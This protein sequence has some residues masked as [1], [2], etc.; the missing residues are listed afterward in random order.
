MLQG[1]FFF[2]NALNTVNVIACFTIPIRKFNFVCA[3]ITHTR[4]NKHTHA[5]AVT[6]YSL[7][8][9][10]IRYAPFVCVGV[11]VLC[12]HSFIE[13]LF[14]KI[15]IGKKER[16]ESQIESKQKSQQQNVHRN[17]TFIVY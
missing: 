8:Y 10:Y 2:P 16:N 11:L 17:I 14:E 6:L 15:R 1:L 13:R 7:S 12:K 9:V 5:H 4:T 3:Y